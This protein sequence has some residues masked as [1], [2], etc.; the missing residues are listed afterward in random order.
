MGLAELLLGKAH[1]F[2]QW[3]GENKNFLGAIGAGLG[4]GQ[5]LQSG[6]SAGLSMVPQA[7]AL[8]YKAAEKQKADAKVEAQLNAS[9]T[10]LR[11]VYPD[12][13]D[14]V[15]AGMPMSEAW[16]AAMDRRQQA[17]GYGGGGGDGAPATVREWEYFSKLSPEDQLQYKL[18]K[19]ANPY[20]DTGTGYAMPD[21]NNPGQ[22]LG[23]PIRQNLEEAAS[24][25]A[26]GAETGKAEG[27]N[28]NEM[29]SL[30]SAMP[31]LESIVGRL[32]V[33]GKTATYT[34]A[35]QAADE[36]AKQTGLEPSQAALDAT[37]YMQ[38]VDNEVLPLLKRTFGGSF[39]I[40]EGEWLRSTLGNT[41]M[42][43][44]QKEATLRAFIQSK[45]NQLEGLKKRDEGG[46][47]GFTVLKVE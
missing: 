38:I 25:K 31:G 47:G 40:Q 21:P 12:L 32:S 30:E 26:R 41:E 29:L 35:G 28:R 17:G 10:W 39:S 9:T 34:K 46:S 24:L 13:A 2:T 19:R 16:N 23:D 37:E 22:T 11:G 5:N 36:I 8:D 1:P 43:P 14:M 27:A 6:L 18:M 20:L 44:L 45:Y 4:Q 33:L 42:H 15:D 3:A 7:D